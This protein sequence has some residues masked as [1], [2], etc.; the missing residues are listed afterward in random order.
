MCVNLADTMIGLLYAQTAIH[1][2]TD[3]S[4]QWHFHS[5]VWGLVEGCECTQKFL[6]VLFL[7][8]IW[9]PLSACHALPCLDY[10]ML[11]N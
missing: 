11:A 3:V 1:M 2:S 10:H 8:K 4:Y 7:V 5:G 6:M 9:C